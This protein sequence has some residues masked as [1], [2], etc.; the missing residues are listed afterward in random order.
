M[1]KISKE[2][3]E[4]CKIEIIDDKK[5]FCI[6]KRDLEIGSNYKNWTV[7]FDK[8]YPEKQK[9][10]QELIANT[11]FQPCTVFL[12]NDLVERKIRI[13][14][15]SSKKF[16]EFEEKLGLDLIFTSLYFTSILNTKKV[17]N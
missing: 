10:R 17:G 14:R 12:R 1:C 9:D 2:A 13:R 6:N 16:L 8:C 3:Y 11:Q 5:Y 15:E 7:I 4:K